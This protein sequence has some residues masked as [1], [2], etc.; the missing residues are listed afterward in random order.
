MKLP[1]NDLNGPAMAA[2]SVGRDGSMIQAPMQPPMLLALQ[3]GFGGIDAWQQ[4]FA[5]TAAGGARWKWLDFDTRL[6]RPVNR[7]SDAATPI[8]S[9]AVP[10]LALDCQAQ[11]AGSNP[12]APMHTTVDSFLQQVDWAGV[13]TRYQAAVHDATEAI[14]LD[15]ADLPTALTG[16][17]LLD[18][19]R[20]GAF[21]EATAMLQEAH[22]RDPAAVAQW[23]T[24]LPRARPVVVYCVYGHEVSRATALQ[25]RA[26][27][28]D[29]RFLRGG[30]D[31]WQRAGLAV[32]AKIS[33]HSTAAGA[34]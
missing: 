15:A 19:R 28:L 20:A 30:I 34:P 9:G 21:L 31:G 32:V 25:L 11:P 23:A 10:L 4:D 27:G 26:A 1:E 33:G 16:A 3:A 17:T 6:G 14:G 29:A 5:A 18:V 22:W 2:A 12:G 13:Y 24:A 8:P 7:S